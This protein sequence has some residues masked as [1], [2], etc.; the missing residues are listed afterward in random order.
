M[1]SYSTTVTGGP[2]P[3]YIWVA[4]D[5]RFRRVFALAFKVFLS[6]TGLKKAALR[7]QGFSPC[8]NLIGGQHV[9]SRLR[10]LIPASP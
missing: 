4:L 10:T 9:A 1:Y 8:N 3:I 2:N 5:S 7:V 6:C